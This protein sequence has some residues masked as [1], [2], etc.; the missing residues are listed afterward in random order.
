MSKGYSAAYFLLCAIALM[1]MFS[2]SLVNPFISLFAKRLGAAGVYIGFVVAGYWVSRIILE[3]PSG[4]I[5]SRFG[6]YLPMA[7]GLVLTAVGNVLS[8][9]ATSP[10]QLILARALM[11]LGAPLFFAVAMTFVINLFDAERRGSAMGLFQG[12]EFAGTI[13]GS[14]FSGYVVSQ[15]DFRGSFLLSAGLVAAALLMLVIPPNIR[16]RPMVRA[17]GSAPSAS[18]LREVFGNLDLLIVSSA[19]FA[20]FVMSMGVLFTVFPLY[21]SER[22][23]FSM[24]SIGF[25]IGARSLGFVSAMLLMGAISDRMGRKPVMLFGLSVTAVLVVGL[26][27]ATTFTALAALFFCIGISAG[28]IWIV[29]PVLAA[30]AVAPH[31]RGAAIGTYRMFFDLGSI[32]GPIIMT[33]VQETSGTAACFYLASALI[34]LNLIPTMKLSEPR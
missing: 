10:L 16:S 25:L 15:I 30:E 29:S 28:A 22:L 19:T 34:M 12:I 11:G 5:S 24:T 14:T 2:T 7:V 4:L 32:L 17:S 20:E 21:A 33:A 26:S 31:Q 13:V 27:F 6:Y 1:V 3:V 9:F 23:G 8:A 18:S